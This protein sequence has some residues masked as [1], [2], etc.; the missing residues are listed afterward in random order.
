MGQREV[1]FLGQSGKAVVRVFK[2]TK[3]QLVIDGSVLGLVDRRADLLEQFGGVVRPEG[4]NWV[5]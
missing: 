5:L 3:E 1:C 2:Y 4:A